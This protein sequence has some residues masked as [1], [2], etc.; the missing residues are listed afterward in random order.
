[1]TAPTI[2]MQDKRPK[3]KRGISWRPSWTFKGPTQ[4]F[5]TERL[6]DCPRPL[7]HVCC[8]PSR[9]PYED[10]RVDLEHPSADLNIDACDLD[11]HF[12]GVGTVFMDPPYAWDLGTRQKAVAA[13]F[14]SLRKGGWLALH[15]PWVPRMPGGWNLGLWWREDPGYHWPHPPI[16]FTL[17]QKGVATTQEAR[18]TDQSKRGKVQT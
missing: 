11:K 6:A 7:V 9:I 8:G 16:M 13:A 3:G 18:D 1:M 14:R 17:W 5:L 2:Q 15:A 12:Q 4:E 10:K